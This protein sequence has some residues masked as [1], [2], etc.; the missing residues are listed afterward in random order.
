MGSAMYVSALGLYQVPVEAK[1]KY[2]ANSSPIAA[3]PV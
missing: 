3:Q 2:A 1:E